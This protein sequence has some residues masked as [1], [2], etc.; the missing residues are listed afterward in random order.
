MLG[1]RDT[2]TFQY[3]EPNEGE[4]ILLPSN[5]SDSR[6]PSLDLSFSTDEIASFI[7]FAK[8][9]KRIHIR[10]IMEG[11]TIKGNNISK[12]L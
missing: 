3:V 1:K 2:V 8:I 9:L 10:L 11:Y 7:R 6:S 12:D 5:K 4:R